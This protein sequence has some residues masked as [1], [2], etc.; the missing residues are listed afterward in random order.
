MAFGV[1]GKQGQLADE[2]LD[3][4]KNERE[5]AVELLEPLGLAER[6]LAQGFG[7][8]ARGLVPALRKRSKSSQSS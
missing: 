6:L 4:V 7:K 3:V 2:V 8:R 1:A 5:A